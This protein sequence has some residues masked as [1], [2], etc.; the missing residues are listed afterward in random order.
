MRWSRNS[1]QIPTESPE[2]TVP[3]SV[4]KSVGL[5][6]LLLMLD[7]PEIASIFALEKV[8]LPWSYL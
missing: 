1:T 2:V 6:C 7:I 4:A 3:L 5:D 8:L